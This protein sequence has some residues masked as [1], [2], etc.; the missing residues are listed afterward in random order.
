MSDHAIV[1][2]GTGYRISYRS[3]G[4]PDF[5]SLSEKIPFMIP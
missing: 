3:D 1:M 2:T 5:V 4:C